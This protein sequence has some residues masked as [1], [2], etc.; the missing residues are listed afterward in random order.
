LFI[1]SQDVKV[2]PVPSPSPV[3]VKI[4]PNIS[5]RISILPFTQGLKQDLLDAGKKF[6]LKHKN[7]KYEIYKR[8]MHFDYY[9]DEK[10]VEQQCKVRLLIQNLGYL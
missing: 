3:E 9:D 2:Y 7:R 6:K 8:I 1:E 4:D 5:D 10:S